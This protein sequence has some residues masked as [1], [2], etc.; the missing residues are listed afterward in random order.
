MLVNLFENTAEQILPDSLPNLLMTLSR[1]QY[2]PGT[3]DQI[4][5]LRER[6]KL[7]KNG[8]E[9]TSFLLF[10]RAW[11][12]AKVSDI[13]NL[14]QHPEMIDQICGK[15]AKKIHRLI[16]QVGVPNIKRIRAERQRG[17]QLNPSVALTLFVHYRGDST[18]APGIPIRELHQLRVNPTDWFPAV[19]AQLDKI[20]D[21]LKH[22]L[23]VDL[24]G[25]TRFASLS[26]VPVNYIPVDEPGT[27]NAE[28]LH[29]YMN[30]DQ[31]YVWLDLGV[32]NDKAEAKAMG[33][34]A[35]TN[36]SG[37]VLYSFRSI[38]KLYIDDKAEFMAF[39][40]AHLTAAINPQTKTCF[41]LRGRM[42]TKPKPEYHPYI[43]DLVLKGDVTK[44]LYSSY[45][46]TNQFKVA[47]LSDELQA[48]IAD[49][50]GNQ[51]LE[52]TSTSYVFLN[53]NGVVPEDEW[54]RAARDVYWHLQHNVMG[55]ADYEMNPN[56]PFRLTFKAEYTWKEVLVAAISYM[57]EQPR[58]LSNAVKNSGV[59]E[60][61]IDF[62][63]NNN[64]MFKDYDGMSNISD[65]MK[66]R[67]MEILE[68]DGGA[69]AKKF[70]AL[71]TGFEWYL[72]HAVRAFNEEYFQSSRQKLLYQ[73]NEILGDVRLGERSYGYWMD[74]SNVDNLDNKVSI[75][76]NL[77]DQFDVEVDGRNEDEAMEA[78]NDFYWMGS[79]YDAC[80]LTDASGLS[81]DNLYSDGKRQKA[82]A[83][84]NSIGTDDDKEGGLER[85][86]ASDGPFDLWINWI[87]QYVKDRE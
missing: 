73:L 39:H 45:E 83:V 43:V 4:V 70:I 38:V 60:K 33:H 80:E 49:I 61:V 10:C 36:A 55:G 54:R 46:N 5:R 48:Q 37:A 71:L 16:G 28:I 12:V 40:R 25:A 8:A 65:H 82:L 62:I 86:F 6:S 2:T 34:C 42:N 7:L 66:Q 9:Q 57:F 84:I 75:D 68:A 27:A 3:G 32:K 14:I 63:E 44:F 76:V 20:Y 22:T 56:N 72:G 58:G 85:Y 31:H 24:T 50:I 17:T 53:G 52:N 47:H 19:C 59:K 67:V 21:E 77:Q 35:N 74:Q 79:N 29:E 13:L 64:T 23:D 78:Y 1:G 87:T 15:D 11:L 18:G 26:A 41:E 69:V 51:E 81:F 30:G